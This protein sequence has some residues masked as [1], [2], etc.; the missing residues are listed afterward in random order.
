MKIFPQSAASVMFVVIGAGCAAPAE[1][2]DE[3][4]ASEN[5]DA[6][7]THAVTP[8]DA[9]LPVTKDEH[10][11]FSSEAE[12]RRYFATSCG[13]LC[14][15]PFEGRLP[16]TIGEGE[17]VVLISRAKSA[18]GKGFK[19]KNAYRSGNPKW[20]RLETCPTAGGRPY[21]LAKIK[22]DFL[23]IWASDEGLANRCQ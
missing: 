17:Y 12:L 1:L 8:L 2:A 15:K 10:E 5:A 21:A 13:F 18:P 9:D 16:F 3:E 23:T 6:I 20:V 11:V 7:T 4:E 19:I 14:S 22:P